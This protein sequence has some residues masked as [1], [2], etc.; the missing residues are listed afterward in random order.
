MIKKDSQ[1]CREAMERKW[2]IQRLGNFY[3]VGEIMYS[4]ERYKNGDYGQWDIRVKAFWWGI[5][6]GGNKVQ[7]WPWGWRA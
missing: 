3:E 2:S 7:V 1:I 6:L 4:S 5:E